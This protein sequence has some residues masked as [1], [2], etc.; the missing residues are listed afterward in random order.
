MFYMSIVYMYYLKFHIQVDWTE[1]FNDSSF[2]MVYI[3]SNAEWKQ[4]KFFISKVIQ[5]RV[6][7]KYAAQQ[8]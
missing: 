1:D 5:S 8:T 4:N 6:A 2:N 3:Y 7:S